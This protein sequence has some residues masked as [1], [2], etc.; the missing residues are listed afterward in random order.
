MGVE[1]KILTGLAVVAGCFG[2]AL[3]Q[4]GAE[5]SRI[6][7]TGDAGPRGETYGSLTQGVIGGDSSLAVLG[8]DFGSESARV[9]AGRAGGFAVVAAEG[10]AAPGT[11]ANFT[12]FGGLSIN[13]V[14]NATFFADLDDAGLQGGY[15]AVDASGLVQAIRENEPFGDFPGAVLNGGGTPA[16]ALGNVLAVKLELD[17]GDAGLTTVL[18]TG[19]PGNL[20]VAFAEGRLAPGGAGL[21]AD[22]TF[23]RIFGDGFDSFNDPGALLGFNDSQ[24]IIFVAE[25]RS[26]SQELNETAVYAGPVGSPRVVALTEETAPGTGGET[27]FRFGAPSIS[28]NG[29]IAFYAETQP[30]SASVE[31]FGGGIFLGRA[32]GVEP[33]VKLGTLVPGGGPGVVF[34]DLSGPVVNARGD[35]VFFAEIEYPNEL[36]RSSVWLKRVG[37]DPVLVA[38]T[39]NVFETPD[40]PAEVT[41]VRFEGVAAFNDLNQATFILSFGGRDGLYVADVRSGYPVV[42]ITSPARRS[43]QVTTRRTTLI[44]GTAEDASGVR[45]VDYEV[46]GRGEAKGKTDGEK[47]RRGRRKRV[48]RSVVVAPNGRWSFRAP[49]Q[50]GRNRVS[51]TATDRLGNTSPSCDFTVIR[52]RGADGAEGRRALRKLRRSVRVAH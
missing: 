21:P 37:E 13:G 23:G 41:G 2:A 25:V 27:Y 6:I 15:Y 32:S 22:L 3:A 10:E 16:Y 1:R 29:L 34:G 35:L 7:S 48:E 38:A 33:V 30:T 52:W 17:E 26:E 19:R 39:G 8:T 12:E 47:R 36:R 40:G 5:Y 28:S 49:L 44:A 45:R 43:D 4:E 14:G 51:V 11:D 42:R 31:F 50:M 20:S 9:W 46:V 24:E 18:A